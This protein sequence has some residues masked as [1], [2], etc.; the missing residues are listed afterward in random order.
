[1]FEDKTVNSIHQDMLDNLSPDYE[2]SVGNMPYDLTKSF[3]IEAAKIYSGLSLLADKVDVDKL[4]GAELT[5]YV[6]QRK[7]VVRK[8]AKKS[9]GIVTVTGNGN[10]LIGDLFETASG[11]QFK[12]TENKEVVDTANVNIEAV[13]AG[14]SGNVGANTINQI[15]V[16][17]TGITAVNNASATYDGYEEESDASLRDRYYLALRRPPTSGNIWHYMYWAKEVVGVGDAKIFPLWDGDN[18]VKIAI[19]DADKL[20]GNIDLIERVQDYIDPDSLG[21]GEGQAPIGAYCTVVS[22]TAKPITVG[23]KVTK[24]VGYTNEQVIANISAKIIE[25]LKEIAFQQNYISYAKIGSLILESEGV[26][27]WSVLQLNT[28]T[29]N[30]VIAPEEV[31]TLLEVVLIP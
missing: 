11:T 30:V 15:P 8:L 24:L 17:L 31:A 29:A 2:K 9:I 22:A 26:Q 20:R 12:A 13:L 27:D 6:L 23:I 16:T 18:T 7:G 19:I 25:H 5:K 1:M 4:T 10:I 28:T 3:A 21:I 14:S